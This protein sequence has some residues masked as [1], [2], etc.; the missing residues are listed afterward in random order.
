MRKIIVLE[1]EQF[2]RQSIVAKFQK[3]TDYEVVLESDDGKAVVNYLNNE[4]IDLLVT[5]INMP[6][7][8]GFSVIENVRRILPNLKIVIISGY[9][10]FSYVQRGMR[11]SV[12]DYLLKP[13][14]N[15]D[16]LQ[17]LNRLDG[18]KNTNHPS[19]LASQINLFIQKY[20]ALSDLTVESMAE[21][22]GYS[23]EYLSRKFKERYQISI[24]K[25]IVDLRIEKAKELLIEYPH[26]DVQEIGEKVGYDDRYHFSK[27]FKQKTSSSPSEYRVQILSKI[28]H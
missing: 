3:L 26:M 17:L 5:D 18:T 16:I 7:M 9:D 2:I 27:L 19:S 11:L 6:I 12:S 21:D 8:D 4:A 24:Y 14:K 20:Y 25:R 22:L 28:Y 1:D 23:K 15:E 13:V 10:D